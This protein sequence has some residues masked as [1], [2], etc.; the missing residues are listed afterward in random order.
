MFGSRVI[1]AQKKRVPEEVALHSRGPVGGSVFPLP[2]TLSRFPLFYAAD[3][4]LS[5][6][7]EAT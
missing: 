3:G 1:A 7:W 4:A 2:S 5:Q 6:A